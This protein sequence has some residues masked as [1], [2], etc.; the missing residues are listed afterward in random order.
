MRTMWV[1]GWLQEEVAARQAAQQ[2]LRQAE[3]VLEEAEQRL[4]D[5]RQAAAQKVVRGR[6][7]GGARG[8]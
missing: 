3:A 8:D 2:Q 7:G 4:H 1:G 5:L 6:G